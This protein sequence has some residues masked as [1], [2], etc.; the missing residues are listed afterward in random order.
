[1]IADF[2][3][4][5]IETLRDAVFD[6][7]IGVRVL[8]AKGGETEERKQKLE[9]LGRAWDALKKLEGEDVDKRFDGT[10]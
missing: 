6:S 10:V 1:M 9:K 2:S 7:K 4:E 8:I 3:E 5:V